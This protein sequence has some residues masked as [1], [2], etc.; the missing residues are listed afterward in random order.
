MKGYTL[1]EKIVIGLMILIISVAV[2]YA[3]QWGYELT[4]GRIDNTWKE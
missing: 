2:F 1:F 4:W 3:A